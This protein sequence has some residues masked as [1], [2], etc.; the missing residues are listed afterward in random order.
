MTVFL[1]ANFEQ[2]IEADCMPRF[3]RGFAGV[4]MTAEACPNVISVICTSREQVCT[5]IRKPDDHRVVR[6]SVRLR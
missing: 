6:L 2:L 3:K 5:P 4:A 1:A